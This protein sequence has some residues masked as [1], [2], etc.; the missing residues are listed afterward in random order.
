MAGT[1][2]ASSLDD[3]ALAGL[4]R[5]GLGARTRR[6]VERRSVPGARA[7]MV[8][9]CAMMLGLLCLVLVASNLATMPQGIDDFL[10]VRVTMK[11]VLLT[12]A[13]LAA[14]AFI[15]RAIGFYVSP[16][17]GRSEREG[18][19][20]FVA[21]GLCA[22]VAGV[23]P[24]TSGQGGLQSADLIVLWLSGSVVLLAVHTVWHA[25]SR[26]RRTSKLQRV[27]VVGTGPLAVRMLDVLKDDADVS[28][29]VVGFIDSVTAIPASP[30][31][32]RRTLATLD[33]LETILMQ[34][35]IDE[36]VV[37]LPARS[38]YREIHQA[39]RS[40]ERIGVSA[41]Y[42]A[43]L[44]ETEV[45]WPTYESG[46]PMVTMQVTQNDHRLLIKRAIDATAAAALLM[47][48][49]PL[50]ALIALAIKLES[51]GPVF[52]VQERYGRGRRRFRMFK[53][54]TMVPDAERL[55]ASLESRNE[56][57]GPVFKI[58][59][60]PR[61]TKLGRLLRR[62]SL[63]ELPQFFNVLKG[64]MSLVGPRPLPVR[65]VARFTDA[66][67]MRRF[68]VRPGLTCLWQ[69]SGRSNLSF[70]DWMRLD[71]SYIDGWSLELDLLILART[72]PAVLRG[73]G[74]R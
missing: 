17:G 26:R 69:I 47:L 58:A 38:C 71:L 23:F 11:N 50:M 46:S 74:A 60:D 48:L 30:Q 9:D 4:T 15:F 6:S 54:R 13:A 8:L 36:V 57:D 49:A 61:I 10:S 41:R 22:A 55:Q 42:R 16:G 44:F 65:D 67:D 53:F 64:D 20:I 62:T 19:R 34:E 43:D 1:N 72:L 68:S 33:S 56:A 5:L 59:A 27:L 29:D 31:I 37:A 51:R 28:Y 7:L 52:Y 2:N 40:C 24:A 45:A 66:A 63:D 14:W 73:T 3:T 18:F 70:N 12:I 25:A 39:L 35:A 21:A 32:A